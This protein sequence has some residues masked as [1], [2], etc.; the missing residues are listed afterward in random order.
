MRIVEG[1]CWDDSRGGV[2]TGEVADKFG[3]GDSFAK[4]DLGRT[5]LCGAFFEILSA[6]RLRAL[7]FWFKRSSG[8][9]GAWTF[10]SIFSFVSDFLAAINQTLLNC[11]GL[12]YRMEEAK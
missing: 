6:Q 8:W 3:H 4:S 2:S 11:V 5:F 12:C 9:Q 10:R 1:K 7:G